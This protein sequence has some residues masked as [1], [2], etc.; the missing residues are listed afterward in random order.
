MH[1][2]DVYTIVFTMNLNAVLVSVVL[3]STCVLSLAEESSCVAIQN[4]RIDATTGR[5]V[6]VE[7]HACMHEQVFGPAHVAPSVLP[8]GQGQVHRRSSQ[9]P[10]HYMSHDL[11]PINCS[12]CHCRHVQGDMVVQV[13]ARSIFAT[14]PRSGN[15]WMR[16]MLET[17][18]RVPTHTVFAG[19]RI[20]SNPNPS[21]RQ[22]TLSE[23]CPLSNES[24]L[25][26][27]PCGV[28]NDCDM[29]SIGAAVPST[30]VAK[31]HSPFVRKQGFAD[32]TSDVGIGASALIAVRNPLDNFEAWWRYS[33]DKG[34][35]QSSFDSKD[36]TSSR[37]NFK[38][39]FK[40]WTNHIE[41]WI[42]NADFH[43]VPTI[44][45]RYEDLV[46]TECRTNIVRT[47]LQNSGLWSELRL[48]DYDAQE[49]SI[50]HPPSK[51][52]DTAV[53]SSKGKAKMSEAYSREEI[54]FAIKSP[55]VKMFGYDV[56]YASWLNPEAETEEG[57]S[58][59][60]NWQNGE[61]CIYRRPSVG[62]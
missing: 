20:K 12:S 35:S 3:W 53:H 38:T 28:E 50:D 26:Y 5:C 61:G 60:S 48:S 58:P 8:C 17:A 30:V 44:F 55:L 43:K 37:A 56:L 1:T 21:I 7:L 59:L 57:G 13:R 33:V 25:M 32:T 14:V 16:R 46:H 42:N 40:E 2:H 10:R 47:A 19:E 34:R 62:Q 36:D 31:T 24:R 51:V 22:F 52:M 49:A 9:Q 27:Q 45:Y 29:V 11:V 4:S 23:H 6:C 18:S 39:F 54:E 41:Y 15:T